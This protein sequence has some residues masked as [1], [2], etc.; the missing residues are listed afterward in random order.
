MPG[1][2][3]VDRNASDDA[4]QREI[5]VYLDGEQIAELMYGQSVTQEIKAGAHTLLVDNT[6]NKQ[7]A[8]FTAVDRE[9]VRFLAKNHSGRFAE[10][11]LMIF[12]AG[13]LRVSLERK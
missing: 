11:L 2:L 1:T 7:S 10:F 5:K 6:W 9:S 3:T 12:G 8:E 4:Q 13:P